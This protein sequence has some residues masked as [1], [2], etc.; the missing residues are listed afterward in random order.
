M[1]FQY[2]L[3]KRLCS[4]PGAA[5]ASTKIYAGGLNSNLIYSFM[6]Y[7]PELRN[8]SMESHPL[9]KGS[10][11][12]FSC[13]SLLL[14]TPHVLGLW[15]HGSVSVSH[16]TGP[17]F[18]CPLSLWGSSCHVRDHTNDLILTT[19]SHA[20]ILAAVDLHIFWGDTVQHIRVNVLRKS[21]FSSVGIA[22]CWWR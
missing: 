10:Q 1:S 17:R 6:V 14:V 2:S 4:F 12:G 8:Q 20:Q 19:R 9:P 18:L 3:C 5:V 11:E 16:H 13:L 22:Q 15:P 7:R 21:S